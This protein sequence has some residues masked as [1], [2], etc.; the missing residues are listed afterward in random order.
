MTDLYIN[1]RPFIPHS[2]RP[3]DMELRRSIGP[4]SQADRRRRLLGPILSIS[5]DDKTRAASNKYL[6]PGELKDSQRG[7][8]P[9]VRS[10]TLFVFS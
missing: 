10:P 2:S 7:P 3:I 4:V 5:P 6:S 8:V 9:F 1:R